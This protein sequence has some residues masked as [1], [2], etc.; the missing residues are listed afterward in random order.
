MSSWEQAQGDQQNLM[1]TGIKGE[2]EEEE[3]EKEKEKEKERKEKLGKEKEKGE[4]NK[5][6]KRRAGQVNT[7][8]WSGAVKN[9]TME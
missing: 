9:K 6:K 2:E 8:S 1:V 4:K 7:Q 3:E 5:N